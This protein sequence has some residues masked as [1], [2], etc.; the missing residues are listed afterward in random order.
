MSVRRRRTKSRVCRASQTEGFDDSPATWV[1]QQ[2][3]RLCA[4]ARPPATTHSNLNDRQIDRY[5][6]VIA[7]QDQKTLSIH[8]KIDAG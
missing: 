4:T 5:V 8:R 3:I 2:A 1:A 6:P 7:R